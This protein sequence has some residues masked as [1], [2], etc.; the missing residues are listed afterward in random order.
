MKKP[1]RFTLVHKIT[2]KEKSFSSYY[3]YP[4]TE[5]VSEW[6][7]ISEGV[8]QWQEVYTV[9]E[10]MR[11]KARL[12]L[13]KYLTYFKQGKEEPKYQ[14]YKNWDKNVPILNF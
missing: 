4:T 3:T 13:W 10:D 12:R 5:D 2:G 11:F 9:Y 6:V 8:K 7:E 14:P 1:H